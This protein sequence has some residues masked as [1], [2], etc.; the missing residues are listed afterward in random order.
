MSVDLI[1]GQMDLG[2]PGLSSFVPHIKAGRVRALAVTGRTR[3][4]VLPELPTI[5]ESGL[6]GY[7]ATTFWGLLAPAKTPDEIVR[8]LNSATGEALKSAQLK[9][10]FVKQGNDPTAS[11]PDE[12]AA[13]I[14]TDTAKWARVVKTARIKLE[15]GS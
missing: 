10:Y 7:D 4:A 6:P 2:F 14:R 11:S 13:L 15:P 12:F 8:K 3:S 1:A 9:D 5:G